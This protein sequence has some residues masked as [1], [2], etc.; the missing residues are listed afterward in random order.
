MEVDTTLVDPET[1]IGQITLLIIAISALLAPIGGLF[2]KWPKKQRNY[3]TLVEELRRS[4]KQK[5]FLS[6]LLKNQSDWQMIAR[7][8]LFLKKAELSANGIKLKKKMIELREEL[9]RI[10]ERDPYEM[11]EDMENDDSS[12]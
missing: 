9:D 10:D 1:S 3:T 8:L 12:N 7:Q 6:V 4:Q 5:K 11:L 2:A